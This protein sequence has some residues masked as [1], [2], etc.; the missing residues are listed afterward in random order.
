MI[1]SRARAVAKIEAMAHQKVSQTHG[2][3]NLI[4]LDASDPGTGKTFVRITLFA[5]R[6]RKRGGCLLVLAPNW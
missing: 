6:R 1:K 3:K 2:R 5:E 4:V